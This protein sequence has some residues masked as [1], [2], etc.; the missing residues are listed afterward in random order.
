M[1]AWKRATLCCACPSSVAANCS[2]HAKMRM[3]REMEGTDKKQSPF[4]AGGG[5]LL[6][7]SRKGKATVKN[8]MSFFPSFRPCSPLLHFAFASAEI[9]GGK[10]QQA[11]NVDKDKDMHACCPFL[12]SFMST[13]FRLKIRF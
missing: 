12:S 6:L 8:R 2:L 5:Q 11:R 10:E 1:L 9:E 3:G 4:V 13:R 7:F